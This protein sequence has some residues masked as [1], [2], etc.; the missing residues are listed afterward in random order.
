MADGTEAG[1]IIPAY[2]S[3]DSSKFLHAAAVM[4]SGTILCGA[5]GFDNALPWYGSESGPTGTGS[6]Q[7]Q[8]RDSGAAATIA[9]CQGAGLKV[10]PYIAMNGG[11]AGRGFDG[12]YSDLNAVLGKI[13]LAFANYPEYDGVFCDE[14]PLGA[15]GASFMAAVVARIHLHGGIAIANLA[16]YQQYDGAQNYGDYLILAETAWNS[17]SGFGGPYGAITNS[18]DPNFIAQPSFVEGWDRDKIAYWIFGVPNTPGMAATAR[19]T[20]YANHHVGNI[21]L[22]NFSAYFERW[23]SPASDPLFTE[24]A[25]LS[26]AVIPPAPGPP[27]VSGVVSTV[28]SDGTV[29][30]TTVT[31]AAAGSESLDWS[32]SYGLTTDY[33]NTATQND[34]A[35]LSVSIPGLT[36]GLTYHFRISG[37]DTD[38]NVATTT[39]SSFLVE[40]TPAPT[41][42]PTPSAPAAAIKAIEESPFASGQVAAIAS[43]ALLRSFDRGANWNATLKY[44]DA[45]LVAQRLATAHFAD[46]TQ[47]ADYAWVAFAG[48]SSNVQSRILNEAGPPSV[49]WPTADRPAQPT[50]LTI[51]LSSP[52]LYLT[53]TGGDGTGRTWVLDDFTGGGELVEKTYDADYGPPRHIVRD[54]AIDALIFGAADDAIWKSY[55]G[56]ETTVQLLELTGGRVGKMVGFGRLRHAPVPTGNLYASAMLAA[57]NQDRIG[58]TTC[59]IIRLVGTT[60]EAVSDHPLPHTDNSTLLG[61]MGS[62][63]FGA[64]TLATST[65]FNEAHVAYPRPLVRDPAGNFYTFAFAV[66]EEDVIGCT[67]G[68]NNLFKS[69]NN[70]ATWTALTGVAGVTA[71]DVGI[72]GAL[73]A[74]AEDGKTVRK[75]ADAGATWTTILADRPGVLNPTFAPP[76]AVRYVDRWTG[77]ACSPNS[78]LGVAVAAAYYGYART[79][80]GTTFGYVKKQSTGFIGGNYGVARSP[81]DGAT[82][83]DRRRA[84]GETTF[85]VPDGV[86]DADAVPPNLLYGVLGQTAPTYQGA[87]NDHPNA[88][89][90]FGGR[91]AYLGTNLLT[92][93]TG[94]GTWYSADDGNSW[95]LLIGPDD[96]D[97]LAAGIAPASRDVGYDAA[98]DTL[99]AGLALPVG[100][101]TSIAFLNRVG[102]G[103]WQDLT[104]TMVADLGGVYAVHLRGMVVGVAT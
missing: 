57:S 79:A 19:A 101:D 53:D 28:V 97:A 30:G 96:T 26:G 39:D 41:P 82:L 59:K 49:D 68:L 84:G 60:W 12:H 1:I 42:S 20:V 102:T 100:D 72:D 34:V 25:A 50:G 17:S 74:V 98:S 99:Y 103:D 88:Y 45:A 23:A 22:S 55:D 69:T 70:C 31:I 90:R 89:R 47:Q 56:F 87:G 77:I 67:P 86:A 16:S 13:D 38:G 63:A 18:G 75:S 95:G 54:G 8:T 93:V 51:G 58:R 80:N 36:P 11:S 65:A 6:G 52:T 7:S 92:G 29:D 91:V 73:W 15:G 24:Q 66:F 14:A 62:C 35:H 94:G 85:R 46:L 3:G 9:T 71:L 40:A 43:N 81:V 61:G 64:C 104:G 48:T 44:A 76:S 5:P 4:P 37:T 27:T 78:A 33:G 21:Y 32:V 10:C 2:W 83:L